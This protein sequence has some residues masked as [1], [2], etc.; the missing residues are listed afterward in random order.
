MRKEYLPNQSP[1]T[2][3]QSAERAS[4][5]WPL[6]ASPAVL[7]DGEQGRTARGEF[8]AKH[9]GVAKRLDNTEPMTTAETANTTANDA[10]ALAQTANTTANNVTAEV[11]AAR[12]GEST[13][14]ASLVAHLNAI[15]AALVRKAPSTAVQN[16]IQPTADVVNLTLKG[17]SAQTAN[18]QE[19]QDSAGS[20]LGSFS[21]AGL[22]KA[23]TARFGGASHY[24]EFESDGTLRFVGDATVYDEMPPMPIIIARLGA[25]APTLATF[26]GNIEQYTFAVNDYVYGVSEI[27][28]RYREGSDLHIHMHWA[29]NGSEGSDKAVKWELEYTHANA[30]AS[31]PFTSAFPTSTVISAETTIPSGTAD[32]AHIITHL[33]TVTGTGMEIN[34]YFLWR[35]RR[36]ASAGTAPAANPFG[37]ALGVHIEIDTVGSRQQYIK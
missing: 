4:S 10:Y 26:T 31:A 25:T 23:L 32:R 20:V 14:Y 21:I 8:W 7:K 11:T 30:D 5:T 22:F 13:P 35:L 3:Q 9:R 34:G 17:K 28:H 37:L 12:T 6:I 27:T 15:W 18:V 2:R 1:D 16:T 36:I 24:S 29:S 33:G 19:W